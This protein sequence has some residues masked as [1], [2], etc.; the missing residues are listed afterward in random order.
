LI[1]TSEIKI[2]L[3]E[4]KRGSHIPF[5][6]DLVK[7]GYQVSYTRNGK[8]SHDILS[9]EDFDVIV[10]DAASLRT[11]GTRICTD[12]KNIK[13]QIPIILIVPHNTILNGNIDAR[14]VLELPF[15]AQKLINR[16]KSFQPDVP[17]YL[18]IAGPIQ[19][20]L[21]TNYIT[22]NG[23][24]AQATPRVVALLKNLIENKGLIL[25]RES[26]FKK[27]WSTDYLGD[28]RSL[29]VHIS[30]LRKVIEDDPRTPVLLL[31][32]RGVGYKLDL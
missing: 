5:G 22:C 23:R 2:L 9:T 10:I 31:T 25:D 3:V 26:L 21:Q 29:D 12:L 4:G 8:D 24:E 20:N 16:I 30:W 1:K 7:K 19:L 32:I 17:K 14:S 11:N 27:V 28:T 13:P 15:T 6:K 18:R